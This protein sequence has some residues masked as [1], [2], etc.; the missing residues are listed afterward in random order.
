M[1]RSQAHATSRAGISKLEGKASSAPERV[2][3]RCRSGVGWALG[4]HQRRRLKKLQNENSSIS[5]RFLD[6]SFIADEPSDD[7]DT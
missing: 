7:G 1:G 5:L 2:R 3:H 6:A 4:S